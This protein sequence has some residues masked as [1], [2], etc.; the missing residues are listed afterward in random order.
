MQYSH[1]AIIL[2]NRLNHCLT[3]FSLPFG[4]SLQGQRTGSAAQ[5]NKFKSKNIFVG[6]RGWGAFGEGHWGG[7]D[8]PDGVWG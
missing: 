4:T 7:W 2:K 6:G 5:K 3:A 1:N 8:P